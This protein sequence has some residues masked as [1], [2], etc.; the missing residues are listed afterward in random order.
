MMDY[1]FY[2]YFAVL[3]I[4][5]QIGLMAYL[6][7]KRASIGG[8]RLILISV[9]VIGWLVFNT[10]ELIDFDP[11]RKFLWTRFSYLFVVSIP[12]LWLGF[13][14]EFGGYAER[15]SVRRYAWLW[16]IP[17]LGFVAVW[18][19][20]SHHWVWREVYFRQIGSFQTLKVTYNWM[21][22]MIL[23][24]SY[25]LMVGGAYVILHTSWLNLGL[26][27]WQAGWMTTGVVLVLG[28]NLLYVSKWIPWLQKDYSPVVMAV[29]A[30]LFA[31][32]LTD[33]RLIDLAPLA[34]ST[35]FENLSD[36]ILMV[37]QNGLVGDINPAARRLLDLQDRKLIGSQ[38]S[39]VLEAFPGILE[40]IRLAGDR[41][42]DIQLRSAPPY[43]LQLHVAAIQDRGK[44]PQG[45]LIQ[46][47]DVTQRK[48]IEAREEDD[49]RLAE[50][51]RD[52][53]EALSRI[54]DLDQLLERILNNLGKVVAYDNANIM[55]IEGDD[56]RVMRAHDKDGVVVPESQHLTGLRVSQVYS[57]AQLVQTRQPYVIPDVDQ[58]P[59]WV[60]FP[61]TAWIRSYAG[62]PIVLGETV[63]G[64]INL[65]SRQAGFYGAAVIGRLTAFAS[66]AAVA[67]QNSRLV[68]RLEEL[69]RTDG[70]TGLLNRRYFFTM[71]G[72]EISCSI[73]YG[74]TITVLMIDLDH[75]KLVNDRFGHL[76]GDLVL[77]TVAEICRRS[78]RSVDLVGRYGGE[79]IVVLLPETPLPMAIKVA[80]RLRVDLEET[81]IQ[82]E[83]GPIRITA[84]LG[85]AQFSPDC[86]T[87]EELLERADRALYSAKRAG[88]NCV[89]AFGEGPAIDSNR[90]ASLNA[91]E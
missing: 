20:D 39:T 22:W 8:N 61:E 53:A 16:I 30:I 81:E 29:A 58:D 5:G 17:L 38:I 31:F 66:Q 70:L 69:A 12:V 60:R 37:S 63:I 84:S 54:T 56:A 46:L 24:Y 72:R 3:A 43:F 14:W 41:P 78:L 77:Q 15:L 47:R 57:M 18:T 25:A 49:R 36:G 19:N 32:G 13:A 44:R 75:F 71:A 27:R 74:C 42:L 79:E 65:D 9:A 91:Q 83:N 90:P 68:M 55:L 62:A 10:L 11:A 82:T 89:C 23:A 86:G 6:T 45:R 50:A 73:R 76:A 59:H 7:W 4:L 87:L 21:F 26:Y 85:V 52:T 88:R 67:L 2:P 64:V 28:F 80:E 35:L 1:Q 34:R 51:L 40:G 33:Y 48:L